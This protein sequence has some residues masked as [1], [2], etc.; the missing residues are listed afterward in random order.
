MT[1]DTYVRIV[2]STLAVD[3]DIRI[4]DSQLSKLAALGREVERGR[5]ARDTVGD[6]ESLFSPYIGRP[7]R[8]ALDKALR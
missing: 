2:R 5:A 3:P 4:H 1:K 8:E 6:I 7:L